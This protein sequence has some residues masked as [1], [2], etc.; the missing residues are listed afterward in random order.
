[1]SWLTRLPETAFL[2]M[3]GG[4]VPRG[5]M[6]EVFRQIYLVFLALGTLVGI[7]VIGYMCYLAYQY[8]E[9]GSVDADGKRGED[10][11]EADETDRPT[12]GELPTG[13]GGGRKLFTSLALSAIIVISLIAWTYGTLLFVEG[14]PAQG[15]EN[16]EVG[17]TGY[18]FGWEF[19][20]PNGHT[21]DGVL[22][23]P[24]GER[25]D[26]TVTSRDVWHNFGIP[27]FKVKS[28][29]IP[30]QTTE[31]WFTASETGTFQAACYELCGAGHSAMNAEV[32]VM[33]PEKFEQWYANTAATSANASGSGATAS[34]ATDTAN[35]AAANATAANATND[36]ATN[37]TAGNSTQNAL[38]A[39]NALMAATTTRSA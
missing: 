3:Q 39:R 32:I 18:R 11:K 6:V 19:E 16:L 26:L 28:D 23:V 33:E 35:A 38:P 2:P 36:T 31:S 14:A 17:V 29:A 27:R 12:L 9:T 25:V 13:S 4:L 34:H 20:Y 5:T 22:R 30:G 15:E 8:R 10:V 7:V 37:A 1:M 24:R 21:T